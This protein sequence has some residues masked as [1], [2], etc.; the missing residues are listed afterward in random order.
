MKEKNGFRPMELIIAISILIVIATIAI[1]KII[2]AI[3]SARIATD[4]SVWTNSINA[5]ET[6]EFQN[7]SVIKEVYNISGNMNVAY[8]GRT[9][10]VDEVVSIK[11]NPMS[12]EIGVLKKRL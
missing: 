6:E 4:V 2:N 8:K 9:E 10:I 1:P 3:D 11:I 5:N 7:I 12:D